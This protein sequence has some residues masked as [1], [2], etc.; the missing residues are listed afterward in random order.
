MK[1]E[2]V[3]HTIEK[4]RRLAE[5]Q[6]GTP[7]GNLAEETIQKLLKEYPNISEDDIHVVQWQ[8]IF[9]HEYEYQLWALASKAH[10]IRL[11]KYN[12]DNPLEIV[13]EGNEVDMLVTKNEWEFACKQFGEMSLQVLRGI[14]NKLWP[15][16]CKSTSD[17][18][19]YEESP[20]KEFAESARDMTPVIRKAIDNKSTQ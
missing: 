8:N 18:Q 13:S 11:V 1:S 16:I 6:K 4:L 14:V 12:A 7:E 3:K 10:D 20:Y 2:K 17:I 15:Q 19:D 9:K 5:D